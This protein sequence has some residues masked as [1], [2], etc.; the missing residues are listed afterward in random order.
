MSTSSMD[1]RYFYIEDIEDK[2]KNYLSF[3][4]MENTG[5]GDCLFMSI[6]QFLEFD[7]QYEIPSNVTDLRRKIV[8]YISHSSNWS[9][10][11]DTIIF[12]LEN[13]L[14][15]LVEKDYSDDFKRKEYRNYMGQE[16]Q[17][18]TCAELQAASEI[19]NFVYIVFRKEIRRPEDRSYETWYNCYSSEDHKSKSKMF[20]F[21]TGKPSTGHFQ[22]M[23][24][25][26]PETIFMVPQ[27]DYKTIDRRYGSDNSLILSVKKISRGSHCGSNNNHAVC[28]LCG[29]YE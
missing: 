18:G 6:K 26:L 15:S 16:F 25:I 20:L 21:F 19:F 11:I 24:P 5:N 13:L 2:K 1:A 27:G 23:Q 29:K 12:N 28:P 9:R 8:N 4:I 14:P 10:F 7:N 3:K 22:F 17:Y